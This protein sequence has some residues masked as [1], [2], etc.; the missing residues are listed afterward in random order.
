MSLCDLLDDRETDPAAPAPVGAR[1]E[2]LEDLAGL[3][4][5][6]IDKHWGRIIK[7]GEGLTFGGMLK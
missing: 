3:S 6:E 4:D 1:P 5:A 2:T 7:R